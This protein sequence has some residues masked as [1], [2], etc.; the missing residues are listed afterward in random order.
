VDRG[1]FED[2]R[3]AESQFA[4]EDS[5]PAAPIFSAY[6]ST[7]TIELGTTVHDT[8]QGSSVAVSDARKK[9]KTSVAEVLHSVFG[10]THLP[11][12]SG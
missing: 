11:K 3:Q 8:S 7:T 12:R 5:T 9:H 2:T 1:H 4:A 10:S 6:N